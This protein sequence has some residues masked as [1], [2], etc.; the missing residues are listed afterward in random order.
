MR[1]TKLQKKFT[2]LCAEFD[3]HSA[4]KG[5]LLGLGVGDSGMHDRARGQQSAIQMPD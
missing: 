3:G 2:S 4:Y 5:V 1:Y